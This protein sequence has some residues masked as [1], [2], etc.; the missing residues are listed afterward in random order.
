M[1]T[2]VCSNCGAAA[3]YDGRCGDGPVLMCGCD[4]RGRRKVNEGSRGVWYT[5][6]SGAT[7]V[8]SDQ[9]QGDSYD[10]DFNYADRH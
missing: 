9:Y 7:P 6:P 2:Y 5:N 4:K 1:S 10:D 3:Y 8:E